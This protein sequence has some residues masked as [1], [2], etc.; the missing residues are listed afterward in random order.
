MSDRQKYVI[1]VSLC[2]TEEYREI[3]RKTAD[4]F[5]IPFLDGGTLFNSKLEDIKSGKIY[6][7]EMDMYRRVYGEAE[8][9]R[10]Q[11]RYVTSD[12]CHPHRIGHFLLAEE[13]VRIIQQDLR[14]P[15]KKSVRSATKTQ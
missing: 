13:L 3:M 10:K 11:S 7:N 1:F 5:N 4:R 15:T 6:P 8:L 9:R 2:T 12:G 14:I